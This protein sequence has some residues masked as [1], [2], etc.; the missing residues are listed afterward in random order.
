MYFLVTDFFPPA[1][2]AW[3]TRHNPPLA[4]RT[5]SGMGALHPAHSTDHVAYRCI[6]AAITLDT[7]GSE[8]EREREREKKREE[9]TPAAQ[10]KFWTVI[11]AAKNPVFAPED[12]S[13]AH[14]TICPA[15]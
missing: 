1:H 8:R 7:K 12:R 10:L 14:S 13:G 9:R 5:R 4:P 11:M 6:A 15:L 2:T 3:D